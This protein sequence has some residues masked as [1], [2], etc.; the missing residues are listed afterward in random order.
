MSLKTHEKE[1]ILDQIIGRRL[2]NLRLSQ[3]VSQQGLAEFLDVSFQQIQKYE[4]AQNRI[5]ASKLF[6]ICH[7]L[8][9]H[10]TFFFDEINIKPFETHEIN[11]CAN[12][13][14]DIDTIGLVTNKNEVENAAQ[15]N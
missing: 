2:R 15:Q 6:A 7:Y 1:K 13:L 3:G 12:E 10:I 11:H 14:K 4:K 8:K 5:S 9:V